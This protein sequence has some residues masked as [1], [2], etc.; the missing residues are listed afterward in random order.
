MPSR[1]AH[2]QR[3]WPS[4]F[5]P[6]PTLSETIGESAEL[7]LGGSSHM[8]EED[9]GGE[10][11]ADV[12]GV[13]LRPTDAVRVPAEKDLARRSILDLEGGGGEV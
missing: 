6:H 9:R 13:S 7:F 10:Q 1:W 12:Q 2:W 3:I 11:D 8:V 5:T 4:V